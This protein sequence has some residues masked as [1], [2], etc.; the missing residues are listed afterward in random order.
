MRAHLP[1]LNE[2]KRRHQRVRVHLLGR[3]MLSDGQ[4]FPCQATNMSPGGVALITPVS[5]R[6]GE[7]IIVYLD[8]IGRVEGKIARVFEGGFAVQINATERKR[9]KLADQLTWLA[10]RNDLGMI[11][12]RR[13]DRVQPRN[14]Y[15]HIKLPDGRTYNCR[16]IDMSI[17]GAAVAID[18][19]PAI[20]SEVVLG[21]MRARVV[22]HFPDGIA[23]QFADVQDQRSLVERLT[24][25]RDGDIALSA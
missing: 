20:G 14:T 22:R 18:V 5:G 6:S 3:F 15:S 12:D 11:E 23:V 8:E 4:E 7:R 24:S 2:E 10:N 9:D 19:K 17:S 13:H 16:V 1:P 25:N 21:L